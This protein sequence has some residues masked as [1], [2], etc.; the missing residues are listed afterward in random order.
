MAASKSSARDDRRVEQQRRR[1]RRGRPRPAPA[2]CP[3]ASRS[4]P[5]RAAPRQLGAQHQR[6][7][8]VE[9]VVAGDADAHGV[10]ARRVERRVEQPLVAG[11]DLGLGRVRR[12]RPAV[13][14]G[15]DPL[16]RQVGA[17]DDADLD[18]RPRPRD[19]AAAAHS[20]SSVERRRGSRAG[21][22]AARCRPRGARTRA[23]RGQP[24][25]R[26]DGEA[27][28]RLYSS[29]SRLTNFGGSMPRRRAYSARSAVADPVDACASKRERRRARRRPRR[30][31]PT[32]SRR[33]VG[34]SS[35]ITVASRRAASSS[36]RI[37][38]PSRLTL[39][40]MPAA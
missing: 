40:R 30:S 18:R 38:S 23:R 35:A 22:P 13:Q 25:E 21:T 8:D 32:R 31:S 10:V 37:A 33:R 15:V 36:P 6:P 20:P 4:R 28:G 34:A 14:L 2:P 9:Q 16:H 39:E 7:G 1:R 12:L 19:G 24:A 3:R 26:G 11:V 29:M 27:R 5:G 17:L